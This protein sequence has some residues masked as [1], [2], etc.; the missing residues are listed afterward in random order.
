MKAA[1]EDGL[2]EAIAGSWIVD[3]ITPRVGPNV[4]GRQVDHVLR[5]PLDRSL[6]ASEVDMNPTLADDLARVRNAFIQHAD[7]PTLSVAYDFRSP[8]MRDALAG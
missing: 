5:A 8:Q 6:A 2:V 3:A 4:D 1:Y 7:I